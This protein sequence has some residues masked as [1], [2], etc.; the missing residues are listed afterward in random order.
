M[1]TTF[2]ENALMC[3]KIEEKKIHHDCLPT[4][5]LLYISLFIVLSYLMQCD[6]L[7]NAVYLYDAYFFAIGCYK[8]FLFSC[9]V[10]NY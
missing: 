5:I 1:L 6:T 2:L 8:C 10:L 9:F 7:F 4:L 3:T